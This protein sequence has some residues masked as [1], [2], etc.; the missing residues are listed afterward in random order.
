MG[1]ISVTRTIE[2]P[3]ETVFA[4]HPLFRHADIKRILVVKVDHIGDFDRSDFTFREVATKQI[5][6]HELRF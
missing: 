2:A 3:V 1:R 6:G 4:G 5:G